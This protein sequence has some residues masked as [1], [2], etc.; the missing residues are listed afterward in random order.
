MTSNVSNTGWRD[1]RTYHIN[2]S[3]IVWTETRRQISKADKDPKQTNIQSMASGTQVYLTTDD[4]DPLVIRI[5]IHSNSKLI[6]LPTIR[7]NSLQLQKLIPINRIDYSMN[8]GHPSPS[9]KRATST[10][11]NPIRHSM[12]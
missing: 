3:I 8:N 6:H 9:T 2:G 11:I 7:S 5:T 12:Q 4:T 10:I 1:E